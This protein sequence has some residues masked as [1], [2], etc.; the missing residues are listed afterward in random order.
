MK[1]LIFNLNLLLL[2]TTNKLQY[3][4]FIIQLLYIGRIFLD[5][6]NQN[7]F[8]ILNLLSKIYRSPY[9]H[10][11]ALFHILHILDL[12]NKLVILFQFILLKPNLYKYLKSFLHIYKHSFPS[13]F[14]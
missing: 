3:I 13:L 14:Q 1:K 2:K 8:Q 10:S 5:I 11:L 7:R 6:L 4:L 12:L 9:C